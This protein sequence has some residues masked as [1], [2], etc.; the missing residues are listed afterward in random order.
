[1]RIWT[2]QMCLGVLERGKPVR[3]ELE[4]AG[5][6]VRGGHLGRGHSP[7]TQSSRSSAALILPECRAGSAA[8]MQPEESGCGADGIQEG[9]DTQRH[10][11]RGAPGSWLQKILPLRNQGIFPSSLPARSQGICKDQVLEYPAGR[12]GMRNAGMGDHSRD[13]SRVSGSLPGPGIT[14]GLWEERAVPLGVEFWGAFPDVSNPLGKKF[15]LGGC[16]ICSGVP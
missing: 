1:M 13:H 5:L 10:R 7:G 3:T 11:P 2:L 14:P 16:C 8:G 6:G 4:N 9:G 12:A 15:F